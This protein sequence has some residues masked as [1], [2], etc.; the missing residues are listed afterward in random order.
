MRDFCGTVIA[1]RDLARG[2]P[3]LRGKTVYL[4][5]DLARARE[6]APSLAAAD[7]VLAVVDGSHGDDAGD[8]DRAWSVVDKARVPLLVHGVGV[9]FRRFFD[10]DVDYFERICTEHDFQDLTQSNKPGRAHRT[11]LYLSPVER[12][13]DALH[14]RLLRC[15]AN[16]SGPTEG[17]HATRPHLVDA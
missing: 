10:P 5:G 8:G 12:R 16:L 15:A 17:V 3:D 13:G 6:L 4:C 11:G 1:P 2:A 14:F 9:F 7:R